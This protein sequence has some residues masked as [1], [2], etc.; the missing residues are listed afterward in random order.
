MCV[1]VVCVLFFNMTVTQLEKS[2]E[3]TWRDEW[4]WRRIINSVKNCV[5]SLR[6]QTS[7]ENNIK[8]K[9]SVEQQSLEVDCLLYKG[10]GWVIRLVVVSVELWIA[11]IIIRV[12]W[13]V[14]DLTL[15]I[16]FTGTV[17]LF[18][19]LKLESSENR[20]EEQQRSPILTVLKVCLSEAWNMLWRLWKCANT[21]GCN[22][23]Q[24]TKRQC[25]I[26]PTKKQTFSNAGCTVL[27]FDISKCME[28]WKTGKNFK[29]ISR[30]SRWEH[31][32]LKT[33][34]GAFCWGGWK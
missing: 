22:V 25:H 19:C 2:Q 20:G 23:T 34:Y 8:V 5:F 21:H 33:D 17:I 11:C 9:V 6:W 16:H 31:M 24:C 14:P 15:N 3:R 18:N 26:Y 10:L 32:N 12:P 4:C 30:F 29:K 27:D 28:A 13:T 1:C 7:A